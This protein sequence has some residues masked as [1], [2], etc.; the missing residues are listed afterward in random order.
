MNNYSWAADLVTPQ[1][2]SANSSTSVFNKS[3][4]ESLTAIVNSF[5][6]NEDDTSGMLPRA[7]G[8]G[9]GKELNKLF[10]Q[11]LQ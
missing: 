5:V 9:S 8:G 6:N 4:D 7:G 2:G 3:N 11:Y 10:E 1:Q